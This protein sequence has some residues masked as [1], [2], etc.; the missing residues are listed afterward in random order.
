MQGTN[1]MAGRPRVISNMD[2][3]ISEL[4]LGALAQELCAGGDVSPL[5]LQYGGRPLPS[6]SR[7]AALLELLRSI[8]FPGYFGQLE[9]PEGRLRQNLEAALATAYTQTETLTRQALDF[10]YAEARGGVSAWHWPEPSESPAIAASFVRSLP[11]I[12]LLLEA[13]SEAA[14]LGD[15]ASVSIFEPIYSYPGLRALTAYRLA[16]GLYLAGV[17]FIPR[18]LTE[19]AHSETGIDIHPGARIGSSFFI[20]H[21]TGVVIGETTVI[22]NH[23]KVYQGV[24]LG[25]RRFELDSAGHPVKGVPRHP[26]IE[27]EVTIYSNATVLGRVRVGAGSVIG[28][29]VWVTEDVPPGSRLFQ[30]R[31]RREH[32]EAGAGI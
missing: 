14:W 2:S 4:G 18:L 6:R 30:A 20:D 16:H 31:P 1:G 28:G 5:S 22:G 25:A 3:S 23:V 32:F 7:T 24:T 19:L 8:L 11:A 17:P 10:V 29:N 27:D 9:L 15:P 21:G 26:V 12:R 13:D